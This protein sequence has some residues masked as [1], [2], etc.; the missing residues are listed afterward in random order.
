MAVNVRL[1]SLVRTPSG[2]GADGVRRGWKP[3]AQGTRADRVDRPGRLTEPPENAM[4]LLSALIPTRPFAVLCAVAAATTG[5]LALWLVTGPGEALTGVALA[6]AAF[7]AAL[8][9][10]DK[11]R[12]LTGRVR[13][14]WRLASLALLSW[15]LG[16]VVRPWSASLADVGFM[17]LAPLIAAGLLL[18]P[19]PSQSLANRLRTV[20]DGLMIASSL[21]LVSWVLVLDPML[22]TGADSLWYPIGDLVVV[23]IVLF[24]AARFKQAGGPVT[25]PLALFG[26]G[27]TLAA[28]ADSALARVGPDQPRALIDLGWFAGFLLVALAARRPVRVAVVSEARPLGVLMPYLAVVGAL[29]TSLVEVIQDARVDPFV[30]WNRSALILL[31]VGRQLLTLLE[32]RSLTRHLEARVAERTAELRANEQRFE[33]LVQHSSDVVTVVDTN[34]TVLYQ[35]ESVSR[36]FGYNAADLTGRPLTALLDPEDAVHLRDTLRGLADEPYGIRLLELTVR[37]HDGHLAQAEMTITNL[38]H[39]PSVLGLVINTRDVSERKEL[40]DQLIHE[41]FHD[42]LT[43]LANRALFKD[44]VEQAVLRRNPEDMAVAVLFLDL[45]GFKEVNDSL[46]HAAGDQ[47]LIKVAQ[48]LRASVRPED[49]V[50]RF[51]GD[52]FAVLVEAVAA[53]HQA[54]ELATRI[55]EDLEEPLLIDGQEIHVRASIGIATSGSDAEDADQLMRNADLAMY[56]AKAAGDGGFAR[57]DPQMHTGL[58]ER[59]QLESDLRRALDTDEQLELHYQPTIDLASGAIVGFEALVRWRHPVRGMVQPGDFITL[60]EGTGLIRPLGQLVMLEAC[61][62][63]AAWNAD[64]PHRRLTM[65]VNV[66]G[67][68]FDESEDLPAFVAMVLAD[69]GLK[70]DQL[71]LEMTESVLMNDTEENLAL[72][73]RLKNLGVRLAIDDFGTGY[74]S[75]AYLRRFPVDTLKIDRSF[76]ERISGP[77]EDAVLAHTIVQL[78]HSLG[79]STV[80]EGIEQYSQLLALRRMGCTLGQGYYF[81]RPVPA[82]EAGRL[83]A[84]PWPAEVAAA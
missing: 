22:E 37:H 17:A 77:S 81:S 52:E 16:Q 60:A 84:Q 38:L 67:C 30:S 61:R 58:V 55:V 44:R 78:G 34:A 73:V 57:Y 63:A 12:R 2:G 41:A 35:S 53:E 83:L 70:P 15:G 64:D 68:Q 11:S 14:T 66:S 27:V 47:L 65:S 29:G 25:M 8:A 40:E 10:F 20:L 6:G 18:V 49:T 36:V 79:M 42:S 23:T 80:A 13:W 5:V 56:R 82:V 32:N 33:A 54:E 1:P 74:S 62:Q 69:S 19:V 72:L 9:C 7:T 39:N 24:T 21:A 75:L 71:C 45:D 76:V 51:G 50:A 48:R 4:R 3:S 26:T 43:K 28:V 59:L 46:G 31:I